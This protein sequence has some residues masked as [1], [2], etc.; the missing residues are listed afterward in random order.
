MTCRVGFIPEQPEIAAATVLATPSA[1][2]VRLY[3]RDDGCWYEIDD[4]G[5]ERTVSCPTLGGPVGESFSAVASAATTTSSATDVLMSGM[6]LTP[7]AG[8]YLVNFG[9]SIDYNGNNNE[10]QIAIYGNGVLS[11][12]SVRF[13]KS[14]S[15]NNE[16][17]FQTSALVTVADGQAIEGR[18]SSPPSDTIQAT[19]RNLILV[20][21]V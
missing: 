12:G 16:A 13:G 20:R 4:A 5:V 7:G 17:G 9:A 2:F 11:T 8:T 18:W 14:A 6:T 1:G 19:N 10:A 3:R 21:L 15:G